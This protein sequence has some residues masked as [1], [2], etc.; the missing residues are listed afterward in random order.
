MAK[1]LR[2]EDDLVWQILDKAVERGTVITTY[3]TS[4]NSVANGLF[5]AGLLDEGMPLGTDRQQAWIITLAGCRW[6]EAANEYEVHCQ[7]QAK[8]GKMIGGAE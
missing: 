1:P 5:L 8:L 4:E 2:F 6:Y 3:H 7:M